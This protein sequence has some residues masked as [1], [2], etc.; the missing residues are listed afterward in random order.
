MARICHRRKV[1][2]KIISAT[3]IKHQTFHVRNH[4][5]LTASKFYLL[6]YNYFD[7]D[8]TLN[9]VKYEI[10]TL[11][12]FFLVIRVRKMITGMGLTTAW[13]RKH[14]HTNQVQRNIKRIQSM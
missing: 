6:N 2:T 3:T 12:I 14:N 8:K 7:G 10:F 4:I 9:N 5:K 1:A 11:R 13:N